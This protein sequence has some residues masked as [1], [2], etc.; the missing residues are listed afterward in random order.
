MRWVDVLENATLQGSGLVDATVYNQGNLNISMGQRNKAGKMVITGD[1]NQSEKGVLSVQLGRST[2]L[3]VSG[4]ANLNGR[5][6]VDIPKGI[7]FKKGQRM[8]L[9]RTRS[10]KGKFLAERDIVESSD[11]KF[12]LHY[13][14]DRVELE[15]L[16]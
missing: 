15:S 11:K 10:V 13:G 2:P 1:Y 8:V 12:L 4:N 7:S 5:L 6:N 16:E 9:L 3:V 14:T